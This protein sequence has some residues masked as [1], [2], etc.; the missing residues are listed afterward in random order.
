MGPPPPFTLQHRTVQP[1][2]PTVPRWETGLHNKRFWL[3]RGR[4]T[5]IKMRT[6]L[7]LTHFFPTLT[8]PIKF[9]WVSVPGAQREH[10]GKLEQRSITVITIMTHI[11]ILFYCL[12]SA[13]PYINSTVAVLGKE[14]GKISLR[15]FPNLCISRFNG[16]KQIRNRLNE[17]PLVKQKSNYV[18]GNCNNPSQAP[19]SESQC[20]L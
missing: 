20:W 7:P 2:M 11:C 18:I 12:P 10:I 13:L 15:I 14:V 5:N 4:T 17:V 19:A 9:H 8:R 16:L 6:F 3:R 1:R